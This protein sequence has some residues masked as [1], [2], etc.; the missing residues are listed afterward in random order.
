M[1]AERLLLKILAQA[2]PIT[3]HFAHDGFMKDTAFLDECGEVT[4]KKL[5]G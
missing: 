5:N 2:D 3:R 1:K 4:L